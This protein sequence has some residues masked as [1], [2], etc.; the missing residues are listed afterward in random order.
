MKQDLSIRGRLVDIPGKRIYRA[1]L[2][3]SGGKISKIE[4]LVEADEDNEAEEDHEPFICQGFI[5]AHVHI[6]SA[7]LAPSEFAKLA[8]VHGTIATVSDPHEI[9]NV[10][11]MEGVKY[12]IADGKQVPFHFFF[13]A[14]SCVPATSFETAGA[15]LS[16]KDV[17]A[18]LNDPDIYYL[19]E[20]MNFPGVLHEDA[21]VMEKIATARKAGKPVDGH[22]PGLRGTQAKAYIDA[23]IST[24]HECFTKE[25]AL[26]K[27]NHGMKILIREGSAAKNFD[28][29]IG[30]LTDHPEQMMFCSDDKHPDSLVEG[31]INILCARA[32]KAGIPLFSILQAACVN[33]I[34]HYNLPVGQLKEG[35]PADFI[36]LD[37][38]TDFSVRETYIKGEA[39]ARK[40]KSFIQSVPLPPINHFVRKSVSLH[41]LRMP[42]NKWGGAEPENFELVR[43]IEAL[44]GQLITSRLEVPITDFLIQDGCLQSNPE[45][46][47]LKMVVI[48]R[49]SENAPV[50]KCFV[51]NFGLKHAAIASSV[52]HD[53]HNII[54]VGTSDDLLQTAITNILQAKG[55]ISCVTPEAVGV[56][57]LPIAGLMSAENGYE[58]AEKYT[59][60]DTMAKEAGAALSAPFMTLSFMALLVIPHLKLSDKGLFD[61]D[62]FS[63]V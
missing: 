31:H 7:M 36:L 34:T 43:V 61:V 49:Y 1:N 8:V 37:N 13:G 42:L 25:E 5:D 17:A 29:L 26:D 19:S 57:P 30:L 16:P 20:M 46:D 6:E 62:S 40:G 63:L 14:P 24:D 21:D 51:R 58:V 11:G 55:G 39:V 54:A 15:T 27:L 10:C 9:A 60:L 32:I 23:G 45:I 56:L 28:A 41:D 59:A 22:A 3:I 48:N 12:M 50:A 52:A 47:L 33:P 53:S 44:D 38:L 4:P 18:L 2:T 35:D